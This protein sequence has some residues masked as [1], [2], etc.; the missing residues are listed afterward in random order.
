MVDPLA[1]LLLCFNAPEFV[2]LAVEFDTEV[3]FVRVVEL[4][5]ELD[6]VK[7]VELFKVVEFEM[8]SLSSLWC[9]V[10]F[11]VFVFS[12]FDSTESLSCETPFGW[13]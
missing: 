4:E 1:T 11:S 13:G 7:F 3:E 8:A 10:S 9:V 5:I 2:K 12:V 6:F